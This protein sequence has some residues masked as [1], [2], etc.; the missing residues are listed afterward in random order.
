MQCRTCWVVLHAPLWD[1]AT[2]MLLLRV[3]VPGTL[4]QP[5]WHD[6]VQVD[7]SVQ[8]PSSHDCGIVLHACVL[9][10]V[11]CT[12][13][14]G[15]GH[16]TAPLKRAGDTMERRRVLRPPPQDLSHSPYDPHSA[17]TQSTGHGCLLQAAC[18][19]RGGAAWPP[20]RAATTTLR[21]RTCWPP[22]HVLLQDDHGPKLDT[23]AWTG[24]GMT[25]APHD[26]VSISAGHII[27]PQCTSG[28]WV[29][30]RRRTFVPPL[31]QALSHVLHDPHDETVQL[32]GDEVQSHGSQAC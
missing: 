14:A 19:S 26:C 18:C 31:P 12:R 21:W 5:S 4:P 6:C 25:S 20:W 8:S 10:A 23:W 29:I 9:Q 22:P 16:S 15:P 2:T 24:H 27:P 11:V 3:C 30:V 13:P 32:L 7:Q 1:A 17:R 28:T